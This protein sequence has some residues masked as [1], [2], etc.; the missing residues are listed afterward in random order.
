MLN[1]AKR[2]AKTNP[3]TEHQEVAFFTSNILSNHL[4][5]FE[6]F[7]HLPNSDLLSYSLVCKKWYAVCRE[8]L[9]RHRRILLVLSSIDDIQSLESLV[10]LTDNPILEKN[11]RFRGV[12]FDFSDSHFHIFNKKVKPSQATKEKTFQL[13]AEIFQRIEMKT[14]IMNFFLAHG[15]NKT[16][17]LKTFLPILPVEN[18]EFFKT[19]GMNLDW[20]TVM[21]VLRGRK[22]LKLKSLD[23]SQFYTQRL[24]RLKMVFEVCPSM[25]EWFMPVCLPHVREFVET[26]R[27]SLIKKLEICGDI[28][29]DEVRLIEEASPILRELEIPCNF[30]TFG[31]IFIERVTR[32]VA[33][34]VESLEVFHFPWIETLENFIKTDKFPPL[35]NVQRIHIRYYFK[36]DRMEVIIC[37]P[38]YSRMFPNVNIPWLQSRL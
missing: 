32:I 30:K 18:I 24:S 31:S 19:E 22:F 3:T 7:N 14:V 26:N 8:I 33:S 34:S 36:P 15:D 4:L 20:M 38:D 10:E 25:T 5:V 9:G 12:K 27:V 16:K 13:L 2:Q 11:L 17:A 35:V 23:T 28:S 1:I 37:N 29:S 6:I 21:E